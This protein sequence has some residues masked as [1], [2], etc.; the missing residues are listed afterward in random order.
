MIRKKLIS[1]AIGGRIQRLEIF[2]VTIIF[3]SKIYFWIE[4]IEVYLKQKM[5]MYSYFTKMIN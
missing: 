3:T 1:L 5:A 2:N 4:I